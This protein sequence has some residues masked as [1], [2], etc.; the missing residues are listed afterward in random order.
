VRRQPCL[1]SV[2]FNAA[3][4]DAALV[5]RVAALPDVARTRLY[6]I[7]P[8]LSGI[9]ISERKIYGGGPGEQ[10]YLLLV[11]CAIGTGDEGAPLRQ[12]LAGA[13]W[14]EV[15]LDVFTVDYVLADPGA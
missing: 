1:V 6:E 8:A 11:E 10:R 5:E 13:G 14:R 9:Q 4:P 15:F 12:L 2:R 3:A 7:D